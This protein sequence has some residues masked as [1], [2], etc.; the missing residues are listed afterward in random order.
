MFK[1][2]HIQSSG[3]ASSIRSSLHW[4]ATSLANNGYFFGRQ[5]SLLLLSPR[6][7]LRRGSGVLKKNC[8]NTKKDESNQVFLM[9]HIPTHRGLYFC[10]T[11]GRT[12]NP[13]VVRWLTPPLGFWYVAISRNDFAFSGK[14]SIFST[15]WG[16]FYGWW[17]AAG[18]LWCYQTGAP[19]WTPSWILSR[20]R[21]QVKTGRINDFWGLTV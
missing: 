12:R 10:L 5:S 17:P 13:T 18:G 4:P 6:R 7:P 16:I 15:R 3:F 1:T 21:N 9:S 20:I 8:I 14:S 11:L 2:D 19:S